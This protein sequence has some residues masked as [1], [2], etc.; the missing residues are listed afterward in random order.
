MI[1]TVEP[2]Y[3]LAKEGSEI[4]FSAGGGLSLSCDDPEGYHQ[5][6]EDPSTYPQ[7]DKIEELQFGLVDYDVRWLAEDIGELAPEVDENGGGC[8]QG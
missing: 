3:I 8:S 6:S 2:S 1:D 7:V 4:C 5:P